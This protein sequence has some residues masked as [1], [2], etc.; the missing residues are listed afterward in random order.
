MP[1]L[2]AADMVLIIVPDGTSSV[3]RNFPYL[4]SLTGKLTDADWSESAFDTRSPDIARRLSRSSVTRTS[5]AFMPGSSSVA[6]IR[7]EEGLSHIST[8]GLNNISP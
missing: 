5:S 8:L 2:I 7:D 1:S 6:V 4:I 3:R